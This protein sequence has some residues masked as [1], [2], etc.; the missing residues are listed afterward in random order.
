MEDERR[1]GERRGD[2]RRINQLEGHEN[3]DGVERRLNDRRD[4]PRRK[5]SMEVMKELHPEKAQLQIERRAKEKKISKRR[6]QA[7][8][9]KKI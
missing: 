3:W 8:Q 2:D 1:G 4:K 6:K 5:H 9:G 7:R